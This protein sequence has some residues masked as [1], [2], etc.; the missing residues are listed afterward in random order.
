[1]FFD[2]EATN[3][4]ADFGYILCISWKFL[5]N[6]RVHTISIVESPSFK[7][8]PTDDSYVV[9]EFQK[10]SESVDM[11]VTWYGTRFDVPF[12]N[13]RLLYHDLP[14]LPPIP[15]VDG[16][17]IA[18]YKLK[19]HSNRLASVLAFLNLP[20]KTPLSGPIW[21]KATAGHKQSIKYVVEHCEQDVRM[22]EKAYLKIRSLTAQHPNLALTSPYHTGIMCP[23]CKSQKMQ[24]RGF[25]IN[26]GLTIFQR[27]RCMDCGKWSKDKGERMPVIAR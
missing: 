7:N 9:G 26:Q 27:F 18:K 20:D 23:V 11:I 12:V 16:W 8:D 25:Q 3:L 15:H 10:V 13:S 21:Q 22:L 24:K 1:M 5:G 19:L 6:D 2:I 14:I 4:N 17:R